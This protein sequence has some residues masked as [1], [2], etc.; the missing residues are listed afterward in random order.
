MSGRLFWGSVISALAALTLCGLDSRP[1]R[2]DARTPDEHL[3]GCFGAPSQLQR[4]KPDQVLPRPIAKSTSFLT[5][6]CIRTS[7]KPNERD[8]TQW[9]LAP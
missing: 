5:R 9:T 3:L 2:S 6:I 4:S 1:Y 8:P 7:K